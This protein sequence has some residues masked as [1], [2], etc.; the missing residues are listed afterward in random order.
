MLCNLDT[1]LERLEQVSLKLKSRKCAFVKTSVIFVGNIFSDKG[2]STDS[3]KLRRI[4]EW[5]RLHN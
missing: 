4:I 3:E 5:L 2:I 1:A